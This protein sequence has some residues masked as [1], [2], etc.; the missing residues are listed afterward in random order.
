MQELEKE[1]DDQMSNYSKC[2]DEQEKRREDEYE[3]VC[4]ADVDT[5]RKMI[6]LMQSQK[7]DLAS[8][9]Q[10]EILKQVRKSQ[11]GKMALPRW[12]LRTSI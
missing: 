6:T 4:K 9:W 1:E 8:L 5:K 3:E 10:Q 2:K 12:I 7:A 11:H